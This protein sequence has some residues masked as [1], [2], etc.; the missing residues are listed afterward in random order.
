ME[1]LRYRIGSRTFFSAAA[2]ALLLQSAGCDVGSSI[3]VPLSD[4]SATDAPLTDVAMSD[5]GTDVP[6]TDGSAT[7]V[8]ATDGSAT[9][10]PATDGSATDV[11]ATDGSATDA[12]LTDVAMGDGGMDVPVMDV[13]VMDG[14]ATDVPATLTCGSVFAT[15]F[16]MCM[17]QPS[18]WPCI[19]ALRTRLA[20][21]ELTR[22]NTLTTCVEAACGTNATEMCA[23][24]HCY[25]EVTSC[26]PICGFA[27]SCGLGACTGMNCA[28]SFNRCGM[29]VSGTEA[30]LFAS[31]RACLE[32]V[33]GVGLDPT[34]VRSESTY[35]VCGAV[36]ATCTGMDMPG[37]G[38]VPPADVP[39]T[40]TCGSALSCGLSTCSGMNCA[41]SYNRCGMLLSGTEATLFAAARACLERLCGVGLDT[42]CVMMAAEDCPEVASCGG[43][44][45]GMCAAGQSRCGDT[46]VNLA[47]D[48]AHCGTCTTV[49]GTG[50]TCTAG[51]CGC[52]LGDT[53]C[54]GACVN[55][56]SDSNNCGACGNSCPAGQVCRT[57]SCQATCASGNTLC[58]TQCV[59]LGDNP[60]NCGSC[61]N[62]CASDS[63]CASGVCVR[64]V[65][66]DTIGCSDGT[67]ESFADRM[68]FPLI[69]GCSGAWSLPGI[70]PAIPASALA[71][72]VTLG[73]SSTTAPTN[74]AGCASSNLCASGWH[75]CNGGEVT[76]R[77]VTG[78]GA[79]LAAPATSFFAAAVSGPGCGKC[80]LRSGTLTGT[81]CGSTSCLENC[82][83]SGDLNNDFFGCGGLGS[84]AVVGSCDGLNRTSG[85]NCG[86]L[87]A[88]W[89]CGGSISESRTVIKSG[90]A[91]GGVLCCRD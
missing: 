70:F 86:S 57:G 2:C 64:V 28:A 78:C 47:T 26:H 87:T 65:T 30:T 34:C 40:L 33:C 11:L 68:R 52:P 83:E 82:R 51:V 53:S 84:T 16:P 72:C 22:F 36:V 77:T 44:I 14:P 85:D 50:A 41:A 10:V 38:G 25:E 88:P 35:A 73:N 12:S 74:G 55:V 17:G 62:R 56:T 89:L 13:P 23:T 18:F 54:S 29:L 46:C 66:I 8:L 39:A 61:G 43:V 15:G 90:N 32:R 37:D 3:L 63:T 67:R 91:A 45:P 49:C 76:P 31:A 24:T 6:A 60:A 7:D 48:T 9:D 20:G 59:T 21:A 27:L 71:A 69:A 5:R 80:A 42:S 19:T 79:D 81:I 4:A 75:I 1:S 58:G